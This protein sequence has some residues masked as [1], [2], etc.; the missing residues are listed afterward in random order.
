MLTLCW[1]GISFELGTLVISSNDISIDRISSDATKFW[2]HL[3]LMLH[4]T[5]WK[6][7]CKHTTALD[8]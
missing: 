8:S 4:F 5:A 3:S 2:N 1:S 6:T 7:H